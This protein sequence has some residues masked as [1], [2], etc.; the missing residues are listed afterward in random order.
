MKYKKYLDRSGKRCSL[1]AALMLFIFT[2]CNE[3]EILLEVPM[4]FIAPA[5]AYKTVKG[6]DQGIN[7]L[8]YSIRTHY[9]IGSGDDTEHWRGLGTDVAYHGEDPGGSGYLADY[10]QVLVPTDSWVQDYWD[11]CY[12]DIQKE[13]NLIEGIN[14]S[15]PAIW[16]N[17]AQKNAYLAE[18]MF[19]RAYNYKILTCLYGDVPLILDVIK[20]AITDFTRAP[21]ADILKQIVA[22]LKFASENL[23][24]PGAESAVGKVNKAAALH[25]LAEAYLWQKDYQKAVDAASAVINNNRYALM[26]TR[27]GANLGNDVWGSGDVYY[28]L[29]S[30]GNQNLAENTEAI[31]VIQNEPLITGGGQ[32]GGERVFGPAYFR[33]GQ[34]PDGF[35]AILGD[36]YNGN[37]TGYTDSLGRGVAGLRPTNYLAYDIWRSDWNNDIRN[38]EH[39]IKRHFYFDNPASAYHQQ[40]IKWNLYPPGIRDDIRDTCEFIFPYWTKAGSPMKHF[41]DPARSGGGQNHK[42]VYAV[43]LAE[44]LLLRAEGYLGLANKASAAADINLIRNRANAT[45]VDAANVDINYIL[46]ERARELY[47]EE[48]RR[49]TL[50]R[51]DLLVS[52]VR[53]YCSNPL[54]PGN[55][56]QDYHKLWPIPQRDLDLN[57]THTLTQNPGYN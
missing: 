52:R 24:E 49:I 45:P 16:L 37:Y 44:T 22:D 39:N 55:N 51:L 4:D 34:T 19:F 10:V 47:T 7:A 46:D 35:T 11:F 1:L 26:T 57:L 41:T 12:A 42:D 23:P 40:E 33:M 8:Y 48:M 28:D 38:A 30:Y 3:K 9:Y 2:A 27:F 20:S 54:I 43:R 17:D 32:Y 36:Y 21:Q 53:L 6:V 25:F 56:I 31:W 14:T 13:N 5:N 18:V 15:D 50:T 29:F